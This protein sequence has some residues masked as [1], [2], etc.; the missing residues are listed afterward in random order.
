MNLEFHHDTAGDLNGA[1]T[2]DGGVQV[3]A[4]VQNDDGTETVIVRDTFPYSD[5]VPRFLRLRVKSN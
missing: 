3:G 4:P 1:W 2:L 5:G